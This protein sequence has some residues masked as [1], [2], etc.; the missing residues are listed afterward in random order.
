[1]RSPPSLLV[2]LHAAAAAALLLLPT[3]TG[4]MFE[5]D[6]GKSDF[7]VATAGHGGPSGLTGA[8]LS[9][10]GTALITS[11]GVRSG[12]SYYNEDVVDDD[13][14]EGKQQ[15]EGGE[16][17]LG[18]FIDNGSSTTDS[19]STGDQ[20]SK[21]S[22]NL[23]SRSVAT[24]ELLWRRN[25]CSTSSQS[26]YAAYASKDHAMV[27][28]L[29]SSGSFRGWSDRDGVLMFDVPAPT[30]TAS[31]ATTGSSTAEP[32]VF[33]TTV[34]W[35][36]DNVEVIGAVTSAD[37]K[38]EVVTLYDGSTGAS[39]GTL[40]AKA[41][42]SDAK[43]KGGGAAKVLGMSNGAVL[44]G[45]VKDDGDS[46]IASSN[47]MA[48][49]GIQVN[50]IRTTTTEGE[51]LEASLEVTSANAIKVDGGVKSSMLYGT[52]QV[53]DTP[54]DGKVNIAAV[55]V[56]GS[57]VITMSVDPTSGSGSGAETALSTMHPLWTAVHSVHPQPTNGYIAVSGTDT[58][59]PRTRLTS[60]LFLYTDGKVG[61]QVYTGP[62]V[63]QDEETE[64]DATAY[65]SDRQIAFEREG[66]TGKVQVKAFGV[67][68]NEITSKLDISGDVQLPTDDAVT[69]VMV[70]SCT[71]S[72]MSI[73]VITSGKMTAFLNLKL[74][75]GVDVD[76]AW[77][78]EEALASVTDSIFLD[79]ATD[80]SSDSDEDE[81][82]LQSLTLSS[83]LSSQMNSFRNF[84]SGG[85]LSDVISIFM[86]AS[87][88]EGAD[89]DSK[90]KER[91]FGFAKVA[92]LLSPGA[93]F[94]MDVSTASS[95]RGTILWRMTLDPNAA[96]S[97]IVHGG[98]TANSLVG[99]GQD[100]HA[101]HS[102]EVMV[103]SYIPAVGS[104]S[105]KKGPKIAWK[106]VDGPTGKI[107]AEG[108]VDVSSPVAQILPIHVSHHDYQEPCRH[109]LSILHADETITVIP[110]DESAR[111]AV[112]LA[113]KSS[114]QN[115]LYQHSIRRDTGSYQTYRLVS[116]D[117]DE[118]IAQ[119]VGGSTFIPGQ[120]KIVTVA[121]PKRNE[122][123][124]S[125]ALILGDDSLLLSY[126][127][128]HLSVVVTA[129]TDEYLA[130]LKSEADDI[131][132]ALGGSGDQKPKPLG[133]TKP[134]EEAP[135]VTTTALPPPSLFINLVDT[136]SGRILH[137]TSHSDAA[138]AGIPVI[139]SENWIIYAFSNLK[140]R[141]TEIG[142]LSLH[143]GMIDKHGITA[144]SAP[145]Q[146]STFSSFTSPKPIVLAKTYTMPSPVTALGATTTREG[147]SMKQ[148]LMAT[149]EEGQVIGIDRRML[150]PRRPT[151]EV[152]ASEKK[153]G[154]HK[155]HPLIPVSTLR[156]PSY[157]QRIE[158]V[159][160]ITSTAA[161]VESQSL[162]IAHGGPDIF[163]TRLSPSR[164]F[165]LLPDS[166][167]RALLSIVVLALCVLVGTLK[168]MMTKKMI[169]TS[170]A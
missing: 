10:D 66:D 125:P 62:Q 56:G 53:F 67:K 91:A 128:P 75:A 29:D 19:T 78:A 82:L 108:S 104:G 64:Y 71:T 7:V 6:V 115:G 23:A 121:Y 81:A 146:E 150:D 106:C 22:C 58:R 118:I 61:E 140:S 55:S 113:I 40:S 13:E 43:A 127:N 100:K 148:I 130:S 46:I 30:T 50:T 73:L 33:G 54:D 86:S 70:L 138:T 74:A 76:L 126:L 21:S 142:V 123:L 153:E 12:G 93:V 1:M 51:A 60:A 102:H 80:D 165:D 5:D 141:R 157:S 84:V 101:L 94:G 52:V 28:T 109:V 111:M 132:K 90:K 164:G 9:S 16:Y 98:A 103:I 27:Y 156:I 161:N 88:L 97:K 160:S 169:A 116:S 136:V 44:V 145:E 135:T 168:K 69:E 163:F 59:Y 112:S 34:Q 48:V 36:A 39:I 35:G 92:V 20:G 155:Y 37:G 24:G 38:D 68:G 159:S 137:R 89:A 17:I 49:V 147:I 134:G 167:N 63:K 162:V 119:Q 32:K 57:A 96:W 95:G 87:G 131:A 3:P 139:I 18:P 120:E 107:H 152:K 124:Q 149:G 8:W 151:G 83:R 143:E 158:A 42:L 144:F 45:Y 26:T 170:W 122:V 65:C 14:E 105:R 2:L 154:L 11:G 25:V 110:N 117:S 166:F 85:F 72:E 79:T 4:A 114:G 47:S 99:G 77:T 133:A 129:A 31:A 41:L 15:R